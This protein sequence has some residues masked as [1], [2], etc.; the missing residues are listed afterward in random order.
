MVVVYSTQ[1]V[2]HF[3]QAS[4]HVL[5][6]SWWEACFEHSSEQIS[7]ILAHNACKSWPNLEHLTSKREHNAQIAVQS[8]TFFI[9]TCNAI[10]TIAFASY[11]T[12]QTS[13]YTFFWNF[14][15]EIIFIAN[16]FL[17]WDKG[18]TNYVL[19]P[20]IIINKNYIIHI[21]LR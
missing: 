3:L 9:A 21:V 5:Q 2:V 11:Q 14:H 10:G 7:H 4:A 8:N 6:E 13:F 18:A 20:C 19:K 17:Q 15:F 1:I 12:C 16:I